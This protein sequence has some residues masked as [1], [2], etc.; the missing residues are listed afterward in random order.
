MS[1]KCPATTNVRQVYH[2]VDM[3]MCLGQFK[4]GW[5]DSYGEISKTVEIVKQCFCIHLSTYLA[6][7]KDFACQQAVHT[8]NYGHKI[9]GTI[10]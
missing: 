9:H 7:V 5:S 4:S 6:A 3:E 8:F 1:S 10:F 2:F